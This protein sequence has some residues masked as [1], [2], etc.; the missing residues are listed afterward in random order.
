[1]KD[2]FMKW[3][4]SYASGSHANAWIALGVMI[5]FAF[6]LCIASLKL[7]FWLLIRK[8]DKDTPE[9]EYWRTHGGE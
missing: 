1:M 8:R 4:L 6:A 9:S 2:G 5:V 7:V 3:F